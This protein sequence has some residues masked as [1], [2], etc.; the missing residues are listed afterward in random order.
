[1]NS[2][3]SGLPPHTPWCLNCRKTVALQA[4]SAMQFFSKNVTVKTSSARL[5]MW[6]SRSFLETLPV[7]HISSLVVLHPECVSHCPLSPQGPS[8][9]EPLAAEACCPQ[10]SLPLQGPHHLHCSGLFPASLSEGGALPFYSCFPPSFSNEGHNLA[11]HSHAYI[12]REK[13]LSG[14]FLFFIFGKSH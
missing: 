2:L 6:K 4:Q 1:M 11:G 7:L 14:D 3:F 10:A 9:A 5:F 13:H 12:A 8:R